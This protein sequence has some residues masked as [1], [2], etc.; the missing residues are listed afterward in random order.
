VVQMFASLCVCH[1]TNCAMHCTQLI[2]TLTNL[3]VE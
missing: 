3:P 2:I 1:M